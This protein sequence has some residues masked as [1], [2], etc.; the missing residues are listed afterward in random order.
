MES[1]AS[2]C[3]NLCLKAQAPPTTF[4]L[5]AK[6]TCARCGHNNVFQTNYKLTEIATGASQHHLPGDL[7]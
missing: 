3:P 2:S 4:H 1:G 6:G 7:T 5:G